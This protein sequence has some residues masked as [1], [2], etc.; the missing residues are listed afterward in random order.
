MKNF[1]I[2][3][4]SFI[5][6]FFFSCSSND[7]EK[8]ENPNP[9]TDVYIAGNIFEDKAIAVYWKNGEI[10]KLT[11][12]WDQPSAYAKAIRVVG[13]DVY[14][15]GE[16]IENQQNFKAVVWK[17]G[18]VTHLNTPVNQGVAVTCMFIS[19]NDVYVGGTMTRNNKLIAVY[20]KNNES[21]TE[22]S[23]GVTDAV[24]R[25]ITVV[26]NTVHAVGYRSVDGIPKATY[27]KNGIA[28]EIANTQ[29][30]AVAYGVFIANNNDAY[31]AFGQTMPQANRTANYWKNGEA[32]SLSDGSRGEIAKAI[33]V[34]NNDV[35]VAGEHY[36]GT[37][38]KRAVKYWKNGQATVL[39]ES[40]DL[41][42]TNAM[43]ILDEKA[44]IVGFLEVAGKRLPT[45]WTNTQTVN[46][47]TLSGEAEDIF[48]VKN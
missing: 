5:F 7:D 22:L 46:L 2:I 10:I 32:T 44:Y 18:V 24:M 38:G 13:Q 28:S 6:L 8:E 39:H 25:D 36:D 35:Y 43:D 34:I 3:T 42:T 16:L 27:W 9:T 4:A 23:D 11:E 45:L 15:A 20:W 21:P 14:V 41:S 37:T 33:T 12:S 1:K 30:N 17:N 47:S 19:N 31:I 48:I 29:A 26:N 40:V